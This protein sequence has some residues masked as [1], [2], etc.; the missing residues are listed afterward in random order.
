MARS[1]IYLIITI[2]ARSLKLRILRLVFSLFWMFCLANSSAYGQSEPEVN[3]IL[4]MHGVWEAGPW[5]L[6]IDRGIAD[7]FHKSE[8][9]GVQL[10]IEYLGIDVETS[11]DRLAEIRANIESIVEQQGISIIVAVQALA[12]SFY[13]DLE[14]PDT[15]AGLLLLPDQETIERARG[16]DDIS[17][18]ESASSSA[19]AQT[20]EQILLLRPQSETIYVVGGNNGDDLIYVNQ[21]EQVAQSY[22]GSR[23]FEYFIGIEPNELESRLGQLHAGNTVLTLPFSAYTDSDGNLAAMGSVYYDLMIDSVPAPLFGIHDRLL[24]QGLAGGALSSTQGYANTVGRLLQDRIRTGEW[25]TFLT[26]GEANTMYDWLEVQEWNLDLDRLGVNYQLINQ[27]VNL[28]QS[29]PILVLI[30]SNVV[31]ILLLVVI[32]MAVQLRRSN[33]AQL[34]IATSEKL[35]RENEEKYRLLATNTVDVIWTWNSKTEEVI[36]CSP[37]IEKLSGFTAEEFLSKPLHHWLTPESFQRCIDL[38]NK[39]S[40]SSEQ[41]IEVEHY[42]K[43]G[44][45]VW[46][47]MSA[48]PVYQDGEEGNWVGVTRDITQR[49]QEELHRNKLEASVRQNQKFESLGTL[50][51][52]IAHDFNNVLGVMMGLID[53]LAEEVRS[54]SSKTLIDKLDNS[55]QKAKRLVQ[56]ILTFARQKEGDNKV[57]NY[58]ELVQETIELLESGMPPNVTLESNLTS[59]LIKINGDRTQI[60]QIIMNVATNAIEALGN[61]AGTIKFSLQTVDFDVSVEYPHGSLTP[62]R[63]VS[64]I[65]EDDGMGIDED[66]IERIFDPFYTSKDMGSGMGLAIVRNIIVYHRG[67]VD[68][69]SQ[70]GKGTKFEILL[71]VSSEEFIVADSNEKSQ[72]EAKN[73]SILVVDDQEEVLETASLMLEKMGHDC[74]IASDPI[75]ALE[76]IEKNHEHLDLIITDYSMPKMSGMQL[77]DRCTREYPQLRV[78]LSTGYGD[79]LPKNTVLANNQKL[80]IL[81]KPYSY[82]DLQ[83]MVNFVAAEPVCT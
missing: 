3:R 9:S 80:Q 78:L 13:F 2:A 57:I 77:I 15:V 10:S 24:G 22:Q 6:D 30:F 4:V 28:W 67:A 8:D 73:L 82:K 5:D 81:Y 49:K 43:G 66:V 68:L 25:S 23:K 32:F 51:G 11:P 53:L 33:T 37:S 55:A 71:P 60:E 21:V 38:Y 52:G 16:M 36:Y 12:S 62:G 45:T 40:S 27:P 29:N 72:I 17:V 26:S 31:L 41:L 14:L 61:S 44:G 76:R 39:G 65:V 56:R 50:A 83:Q 34:A 63:Y 35:A 70:P 58:S 74:L 46:C 18:V 42:T 79:A 7:V 48:H 59:D 64:L 69:R 75:V 54:D 47:E 1:N 20:I 19:I